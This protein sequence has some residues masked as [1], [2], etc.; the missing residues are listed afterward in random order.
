MSSPAPDFSWRI[1]LARDIA[2]HYAGRPGFAFAI[3]GGST[4]RGESDAW[5]DLDILIYWET[6]DPASVETPPLS[7]E[8][9]RRFTWRTTFADEVW[10]EQYFI[11]AQKIDVAHAQVSWWDR[12][13]GEVLD[14]AEATDWKQGTIGGFLEAIPLIGEAACE[15]WRE[16]IAHYPDALGR[17]MIEANLFFY[18]PWFIEH[19]GLARNDLY[20]Y[21][22]MLI[23]MLRH[24]MGVLAG[25][26]RVCF[27]TEKFKRIGQTAERFAIRPKR[28]RG[29]ARSA[30]HAAS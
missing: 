4:A 12:L 13:V 21:H 9:V 20:A 23:E 18:P 2:K 30:V 10:L 7:G 14:Q 3:L 26:N 16:R 5:S 24:L 28:R 15:P 25:L 17:K 19:Q 22:D 1:D 8:G 6:F 27:S 29:P 11:G